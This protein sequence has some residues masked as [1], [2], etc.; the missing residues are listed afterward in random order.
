LGQN[1]CMKYLDEKMIALQQDNKVEKIV[2]HASSQGTATALN[3]VAKNPTK[4]S[5][6]ILEAVL[7]SGNSAVHHTVKN[8]ILPGAEKLPCSYYWMP[9]CAKVTFPWYNPGGTQAIFSAENIP[10]N[11]PIILIHSVKDPQL[12]YSDAL[13][14]YHALRK[15]GNPNI[16]LITVKE[17]GHV[18]MLKRSTEEVALI[19][20]I[21]KNHNLPYSEKALQGFEKIE[22]SKFQP[23]LEATKQ[24][25]DDLVTKELI[26]Q[27]TIAPWMPYVSIPMISAAAAWYFGWL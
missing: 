3:Y 16:Y 15:A 1:Q 19:N 5:A 20:T 12:S 26:H 23:S 4:V 17:H 13:A 6:I 10:T 25:F 9:Y 8:M 27:K 11:V 24:H 14:V 18:F 7:A 21:F 2:I 22:L